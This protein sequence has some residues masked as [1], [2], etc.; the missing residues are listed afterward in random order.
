[1]TETVVI[2][3]SKLGSTRK[4]AKYIA[5]GLDADIFDLNEQS[6]IDLSRFGRVIIGTGIYGGRPNKLV[7]SFIENNKGQ[8]EGRKV[9]MFICCA[10][11]DEKGKT[12]CDKVSMT[13]G[14]NDAVF[15]P[16]VRI[17]HRKGLLPEVDGYI[18]R[19]KILDS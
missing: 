13:L 19:L 18:S 17:Q 4:T 3:A 8:L 5:E 9:G 15:F 2:Y 12:Q 6:I 11:D 10:F 14:I 16:G 7:A 1:M